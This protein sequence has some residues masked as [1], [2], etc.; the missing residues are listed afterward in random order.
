M[1]NKYIFSLLFY[2]LPLIGF[3]QTT[4]I[5]GK[6]VDESFDPLIGVNIKVKNSKQGTVTDINGNF[7]MSVPANAVL[8]ISY[9]GFLTKEEPLAGRTTLNLQLSKNADNLEEVVIVGFGKQKKL[10]NVSA[11]SQITSKELQASGLT[12]SI[13]VAL[14]GTIPGLV[15]TNSS[16]RPGL[17]TNKIRLRGADA[18][19]LYLVDGIERE[20]NDIDFN[21]IETFSVFKDAASTAIYGFKGANGVILITTKRGKVGKPVLK[22]SAN[23]GVRSTTIN[24]KKADPITAM[25]NYNQGRRNDE[26]FGSMIPQ[27]EIDA[28]KRN[29]GTAGPNNPYFPLVDWW[30]ETMGS[31]GSQTNINMN[32]S[33]GSKVASYFLSF[34]FDDQGDIYKTI[35]QPFYDP[36][37]YN[38]KFNFRGNF[39][40]DVTKSTKLSLNIAGKSSKR[41]QVNYRID[42]GGDG[43]SG[44]DNN[45]TGEAEFYKR[46]YQS[47]TFS[48]PV[49]YPDGTYA[50]NKSGMANIRTLLDVSGNRTYRGYEGMFDLI[51]NQKLD[52]ITKGL[53]VAGKVSYNN[54]SKYESKIEQ[55]NAVNSS[56]FNKKYIRTYDYSKPIVDTEGKFVLDANGSQTFPILEE[57][58][59]PVN[60]SLMPTKY[61][62]S[63]ET[64][65]DYSRKIYYEGLIE[66]DNKFGKIHD[67][68]MTLVG[69][70]N[71]NDNP[72]FNNGDVVRGYESFSQKD[73]SLIGRLSYNLMGRYSL[74][75]S[76][77]YNGSDR[78]APE[79]RYFTA[80]S[81][82]LNWRLS[83]EP[84]FKKSIGK[85]LSISELKLR[86]SFGIN[87]DDVGDGNRFNYIT[88]YTIPSET[89]SFGTVLPKNL[90]RNFKE[91]NIGVTD[92]DFRVTTKRNAGIDFK[93]LKNGRLSGS[94]DVF[95]EVRTNK[96]INI[97][98]TPWAP[99]SIKGSRG[100][101]KKRG[102]EVEVKW[103]VRNAKA[104]SYS[105][106]IGHNFS[107][108]R[109][110]FNNDPISLSQ[111]DIIENKPLTKGNDKDKNLEYLY[112]N[113]GFYTHAS[114]IV[115]S[116]APTGAITD[117]RPGDLMFHDRFADGTI[118]RN[119]EMPQKYLISPTKTINF[120]FKVG[121]KNLS[122]AGQ[123]YAVYDYYRSV[124]NFIFWDFFNDRDAQ[125]NVNN[126]W[127]PENANNPDVKPLI[128]VGTKKNHSQLASDFTFKDAS[129]VR[130][131]NLTLNYDF[132]ENQ[133]KKFGVK[134]M[135]LFLTGNNLLTLTKFDERLDPEGDASSYPLIARYSIGC[136]LEF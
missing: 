75:G 14:Q 4:A 101:D 106:G 76:V 30:D 112:E 129:F 68:K 25:L 82:G 128:R 80:Y 78:F 49:K 32:V 16:S 131:K 31:S 103:D 24:Y 12:S 40:F 123:W 133:L 47:P 104:W 69:L 87:G 91:G 1:K 99:R 122:L 60:P 95:D 118:T 126:T 57:T 117:L 50:D 93:M 7:K 23:F 48:F 72:K 105:L 53:R 92:I 109:V 77:S 2:L 13:N 71:I 130:L 132:S 97:E 94:F 17:E 111:R 73:Q 36:S 45:Q 100:E 90:G 127:T 63:N 18:N 11:I 88:T 51:M 121:Y 52:F 135:N 58:I 84:F 115:N 102:Y 134:N 43:E 114:D 120:N 98:T 37:F 35:P 42:G 55:Q 3:S 108:T 81:A 5:S 86:A 33:G 29:I 64:F 15:V 38:R 67:V 19:A 85:S 28:W 107:D 119:D 125:T 34:G 113:A 66:Y 46:L 61:V 22:L 136:R 89:V 27:S 65:F 54:T 96:L 26:E 70:R 6:I 9:I 74:E 44:N 41:G 56:N 8:V 20:F 83:E 59:S 110:V 39:D 21:E 62:E 116:P 124:P 10:S 79:N